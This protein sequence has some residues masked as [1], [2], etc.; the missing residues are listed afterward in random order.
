MKKENCRV[1]PEIAKQWMER[2]RNIRKASPDT[3]DLYSRMME[4]GEWVDSHPDPICFDTENQL[5]N[6]QHRLLAVIKSGAVL[7]MTVWWG[8]DEVIL[9]SIDTGRVRKPWESQRLV[10]GYSANVIATS[11]ASY[12]FKISNGGL[13]GG[14]R[15]T[16]NDVAQTY[17]LWRDEIDTLIPRAIGSSNL[18]KASMLAALAEFLKRDRKKATEFIAALYMVDGP[19]KPARLLRDYILN[20][21]DRKKSSETRIYGYTVTACRYHLDGVCGQLNHIKAWEEN[22]PKT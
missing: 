19:I 2:N 11:I 7:N 13:I 18:R 8:V 17:D 9:R 6:G 16:R 3:V 22:Q 1:T 4:R 14:R 12:L 5:K 20:N 10:D 21:R 15:P